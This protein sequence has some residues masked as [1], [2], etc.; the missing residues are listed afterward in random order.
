MPRPQVG[1]TVSRR[2]ALAVGAAGMASLV[3]PRAL[4]GGAPEWIDQRRI[5]PF[6]CRA[7]FPLSDRLLAEADLARLEVELRR[8]LALRPCTQQIEVRLLRNEKQHR[9]LIAA[10]HPG[11]P[12][13]RALFYKVGDRSI[14]YA[15]QHREL[16]I[17]LR[18]EC[19]HALLHA[20]L[21]MVPLWLDEGLAEYF[22]P[23]PAD[24]ARGP[25]HLRAVLRDAGRG[26]LRSL[27]ELEK[28]HELEEM[29]E[30]DY[31][32]AWAWT[33]FLLHGPPAA[34]QELWS[35]LSSLRRFE[36]PALI[37]EQLSR[38]FG[39]PEQALL[40]HFRGWP[41]VLRAAGQTGIV[42]G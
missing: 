28:K 3:A 17:D 13:R 38:A 32:Y 4:A 8:V 12:Y 41:A 1:H 20:D 10:N 31:R 39:Q 27:K 35:L 24:R 5:G 42:R 22:E 15:Y 2:R 9:R 6:V 18:H 19:T 34:S 33:H 21:P 7:T 36:P 23:P 37:S 16:P 14:I 11:A 30:V 40:A 25:S 29:T 26:R